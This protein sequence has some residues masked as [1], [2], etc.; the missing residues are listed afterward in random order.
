MC[1]SSK[2]TAGI[3]ESPTHSHG[4]LKCTSQSG[5]KRQQH[6]TYQHLN[7]RG[8]YPAHSY[9]ISSTQ[10]IDQRY[11]KESAMLVAATTAPLRGDRQSQPHRLYRPLDEMRQETRILLI[12]KIEPPEFAFESA[13][14]IDD[15][16]EAF[17]AISWCWGDTSAANQKNITI[18]GCGLSV[19]ENAYEVLLE[20]CI[21]KQKKRIWIDAVCINQDDKDERS[22]QVAMMDAIYKKATTTLVWLGKDGGAAKKAM[23]MI[24]NIVK[25]RQVRLNKVSCHVDHGRFC[26]EKN[27]DPYPL[28]TDWDAVSSL[29]SATWFTRFWIIQEVVLSKH[30]HVFL[31]EYEMCWSHLVKAA[32]YIKQNG[33]PNE[34]LRDSAR[35]GIFNAA[36]I[37][38]MQE[39]QLDPLVLLHLSPEFGA[40]EPRDR[41]FALYG[42][43]KSNKWDKGQS[44]LHTAFSP[45]YNSRL[46]D[47]YTDATRAA[48]TSPGGS[49]LLL[50]AQCLV[51]RVG[52]EHPDTD[53][54]SWVPRFHFVRDDARGSYKRLFLKYKTKDGAEVARID[55]DTP[56][57]I[58]R[59][60]GVVIDSVSRV[61]EQLPLS[62]FHQDQNSH[63]HCDGVKCDDWQC[64]ER[65]GPILR[66]I[67]QLWDAA[68]AANSQVPLPELASMLR[69]T[70][71]GQSD[72][73][74][75]RS[76]CDC[77][78]TNRNRFERFVFKLWP[79]TQDAPFEDR[80]VAE[81]ER[82]YSD[83]SDLDQEYSDEE[84]QVDS[85]D[86]DL[87]QEYPDEDAVGPLCQLREDFSHVGRFMK[88]I[89]AQQANRRFFLANSGRMGSAAPRS[90]T[91]DKICLVSGLSVPLVL[92]QVGSE[93]TL[94]GDAYLSGPMKVHTFF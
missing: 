5:S 85:D 83:D 14:M 30:V 45:N 39:G 25:W 74:I 22:Q 80:G 89:I 36:T 42:L 20:L 81:E 27:T 90:R 61:Y 92:R 3:Y 84:E 9:E 48:I 72:P 23:E 86:S 67:S 64:A 71:L 73:T 78:G 56:C 91:G 11:S 37:G 2:D 15:Q 66:I 62:V 77:D 28:N 94:I 70:L 8:M 47:V 55:T 49:S 1:H 51:Q 34:T 18:D 43:L 82:V 10:I 76:Y 40:T 65:R 79:S 19:S 60:S 75:S 50:T 29:F 63:E 4:C 35:T 24:K 17:D 57:N 58:L 87:D 12:T 33:S 59:I 69:T 16:L 31:G 44:T 88:M 46:V 93:W 21:A 7:T 38:Q 52:C 53:F 68:I 32:H 6:W 13:S 26:M 41:V 54:P